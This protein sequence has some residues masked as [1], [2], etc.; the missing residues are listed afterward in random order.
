VTK[1]ALVNERSEGTHRQQVHDLFTTLEAVAPQTAE[2]SHRR[3]RLVREL[4]EVV[5]LSPT[6]H[7]I[8]TAGALLADTTVLH[9]LSGPSGIDTDRAGL[10]SATVGASN[11]SFR[12][13]S[14]G[15][16]PIINA[17]ISSASFG[18]TPLSRDQD[19]LEFDPAGALTASQLVQTRTGLSRVA[20]VIAHRF[21]HFDGGG[22]PH[23]L[24]G[25]A[26][27]IGARILATADSLLHLTPG[28]IPGQLEMLSGVELDPQ[29][30]AV[31]IAMLS[32][33]NG[34][35]TTGP[36]P[37]GQR[38]TP[39]SVLGLLSKDSTPGKG[40]DPGAASPPSSFNRLDALVATLEA[41]S[42][43]DQIVRLALDAASHDLG[44]A[45]V[46]L[47]EPETYPEPPGADGSSNGTRN[48]DA[49]HAMG[50][51]V[52]CRPIKVD[53]RDH[54]VLRISPGLAGPGE[55]ISPVDTNSL[56]ESS[57]L[58]DL[59]VRRVGAAIA[60][61]QR[62]DHLAQ[63]A[64]LDPL[65]GVGNRRV[66]EERLGDVFAALDTIETHDNGETGRTAA[67]RTT[68]SRNVAMIIADVDG[69]KRINDTLG[70]DAGDRTIQLVADALLEAVSHHHDAVVCRIG[71]DE[72]CCVLEGVDADQARHIA[73]NAATIAER[74]N[75]GAQ[76]S[77]GIAMAG[78]AIGTG[79][80]LL[81]AADLAQYQAKRDGLGTVIYD[82]GYPPPDPSDTGRRSLRDRS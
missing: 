63:Q 36:D 79:R 71:G 1:T 66:L 55:E 48:G 60:T 5:G 74:L 75:A 51:A 73:S 78:G 18:K 70:H 38:I 23:G 35:D 29:L 15:N 28:T 59:A 40:G 39:G 54:G 46:E 3:A 37:S 68:M 32:G 81:R 14:F 30:V 21:E 8:A 6:E 64:L 76:L 77:C 24:A 80:D 53:G 27:P 11:S 42:D 25:A 33:T 62:L 34:I 13:A 17:P 69:L 50:P 31:A 41:A 44:G 65:T 7:F 57:D 19:Q 4:A 43:V 61:S 52:V 56:N 9:E 22:G 12:S 45:M 20:V 72:F 49:E 26:I 16:A 82:N 67:S 47:L 58:V 2:R 10:P